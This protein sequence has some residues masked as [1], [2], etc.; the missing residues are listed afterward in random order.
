MLNNQKKFCDN[1]PNNFHIYEEI[2][3][4]ESTVVYKGRKKKTI[5]YIAVK[6]L[7]KNKK[8]K[9]L[10]EVKISNNLIHHN[11]L[12]FYNWYETKNHLWMIVEFCAGGDLMKIIEKDK[13]LSEVEIKKL[14]KDIINGLQYMHSSGVIHGDLKPS[15]LLLNEYNEVRI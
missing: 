10:N 3:I 11:I 15:N 2:G 13:Q 8:K 5:E 9:V 4:G 14:G 12:R 7:E 1:Q 6:S